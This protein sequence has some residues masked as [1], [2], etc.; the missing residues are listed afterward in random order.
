MSRPQ[1]PARG[2]LLQP[3][4]LISEMEIKQ[5]KGKQSVVWRL[6][7]QGG[8]PQGWFPSLEAAGAPTAAGNHTRP[9]TGLAHA[10]QTRSD[11]GGLRRGGQALASTPPG[12]ERGLR[13][14]FSGGHRGY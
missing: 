11:A 10:N 3:A 8:Y 14:P 4:F 2:H 12:A 6:N 7:K 5:K 9:S 13:F 1:P